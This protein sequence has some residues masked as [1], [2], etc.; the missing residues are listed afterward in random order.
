MNI[1]SSRSPATGI[2]SLGQGV[3]LEYMPKANYVTKADLNKALD[4]S[5]NKLCKEINADF[6][7]HIGVM[8]EK[9][10][11]EVK[12]LAEAHQETDKKIGRLDQKTGQLN[13]KF[14]WLGQKVDA[15]DQKTDM[16]IDTLGGMKVEITEINEKLDNKVDQEEFKK[17]EQKI[18]AL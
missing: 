3:K 10:S 6:K 13:Q 7:E 17:L 4:R 12:L 1:G 16:I 8:Y 5:Q 15:I 9:F 14:E 18:A 11:D 2:D